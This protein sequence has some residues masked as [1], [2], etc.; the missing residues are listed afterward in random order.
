MLSEH[1]VCRANGRT[2][3]LE[4]RQPT[5]PNSTPRNTTA[6]K[7]LRR[8]VSFHQQMPNVNDNRVQKVMFCSSATKPQ[9]R[10]LLC[11]WCN[12]DTGMENSAPCW[13]LTISLTWSD[14]VNRETIPTA[15][16]STRLQT[17]PHSVH[18]CLHLQGWH[19]QN[20]KFVLLDTECDPTGPHAFEG[21][22]TT[23]YYRNVL[24]STLRLYLEKCLPKHEGDV[25]VI[26]RA[27]CII[28][29][30]F[31]SWYFAATAS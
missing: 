5:S 6:H 22:S 18:G 28:H 30:L 23:P 17:L 31:I 27:T 4:N 21:C 24:G 19:F 14:T 1:G 13:F 10:V 20:R 16:G 11:E 26:W 2:A 3:V 25:P 7:I 8:I 9:L 29:W 12:S 15:C